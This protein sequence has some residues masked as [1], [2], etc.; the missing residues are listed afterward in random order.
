MQS[1]RVSQLQADAASKAAEAEEASSRAAGLEGE[2]HSARQQLDDAQAHTASLQQQCQALEADKLQLQHNLSVQGADAARKVADAAVAA[3]T[4][5][6]AAAIPAAGLHV[7]S[8]MHG[9]GLGGAH[10]HGGI[11]AR[12]PPPGFDAVP[13]HHQ[14]Q[15]YPGPDTPG[16]APGPLAPP[17][18]AAPAQADL[19]GDGMPVEMNE[20]QLVLAFLSLLPAE[21]NQALRF[22]EQTE[23]EVNVKL[24][25]L[26]WDEHY[27]Y[28]YGP[29]QHFMTDRPMVFGWRDDGAFYKYHNS[30]ELVRNKMAQDAA[31]AAAAAAPA[32]PA[33]APADS[34]SKGGSFVPAHAQQQ[35]QGPPSGGWHSQFPAHQ[36][37]V[38]APMLG[39]GQHS[40]HSGPPSGHGMGMHMGAPPAHQGGPGGP[41]PPHM[42]MPYYPYAPA[43]MPMAAPSMPF[44]SG[45]PGW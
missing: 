8:G 29:M 19:M 16:A 10:S 7:S 36:Q 33:P 5:A 41:V 3:A 6:S 32:Q 26:T 12:L 34:S 43:S 40:M 45:Q 22:S 13:L 44:P 4:A 39:Q 25:P 27:Q 17:A 42:G 21:A 30:E 38:S 15:Q 14:Q 9:L 24:M 28:K 1:S 18:A 20:H 23:T 35:P 11:A 2:L 31:A 37:H